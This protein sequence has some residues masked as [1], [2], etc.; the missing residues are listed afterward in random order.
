MNTK[1]SALHLFADEEGSCPFSGELFNKKADDPIFENGIITGVG[2]NGKLVYLGDLMD[3]YPNEIRLMLKMIEIHDAKPNQITL[4]AGNR[5][6]NKMRLKDELKIEGIKQLKDKAGLVELANELA[7][8]FKFVDYDDTRFKFWNQETNK[9]PL[10]D[11]KSEDPVKRLAACVSSLM[12]VN[13]PKLALDVK[14][15]EAHSLGF[16][17]NQLNSDPA[18]AIFVCLLY[19]ILAGGYPEP[20]TTDDQEFKQ[21]FGLYG[22]YLSKCK[23]MSLETV[24]DATVLVAHGGVPDIISNPIGYDQ[25][26]TKNNKVT[27]TE[28]AREVI[29]AINKDFQTHVQAHFHDPEKTNVDLLNY[30]V[31]LSGP[32]Q[33]NDLHG[34]NNEFTNKLSPIV[35]RNL[36]NVQ[37]HKNMYVGG[38]RNI[39]YDDPLI[40]NLKEQS[41]NKQLVNFVVFGHTPQGN[42][43]TVWAGDTTATRQTIF[44]A[45]DVSN[46]NDDQTANYSTFAVMTIRSAE[47]MIVRG[48]YVDK[49]NGNAIKTFK[50]TLKEYKQYT[51]QKLDGKDYNFR[52]T[53]SK[54]RLVFT[55]T[56]IPPFSKNHKFGDIIDYNEMKPANSSGLQEIS[57]L[58]VHGTAAVLNTRGGGGG[59]A[60]NFWSRIAQ[61]LAVTLACAIAG[62]FRS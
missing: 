35:Y 50:N 61:G 16:K 43:P 47:D 27:V 1:I 25:K 15:E 6:V 12:G 5:D 23:I 31:G 11:R 3:R 40:S 20:E 38:D 13:R 8:G 39:N 21:L 26:N 53:D 14:I 56:N 22:K 45:I 34:P 28:K 42:A 33:D 9:T 17:T 57:P 30:Y 55:A 51:T 24:K 44:A 18:K 2:G 54:G 60:T 10:S 59:K 37:N 32:L 58:A 41:Y 29:D 4:I 49:K 7:T 52:Y 62:S 36:L 48:Q 46:S 19:T